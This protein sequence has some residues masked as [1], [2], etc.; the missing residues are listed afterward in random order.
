MIYQFFWSLQH[1]KSNVLRVVLLL[2]HVLVENNFG[3]EEPM[4][5]FL[6]DL[7]GLALGLLKL[8]LD[9]EVVRVQGLQDCTLSVLEGLAPV[10]ELFLNFLLDPLLLVSEVRVLLVEERGVLELVLFVLEALVHGDQNLGF[11]TD[12]VDDLLLL[13]ELVVLVGAEQGAVR[14]NSELARHANQVQLLVVL[15]AQALL[16][17]LLL[18]LALLELLRLFVVELFKLLLPFL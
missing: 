7:A 15:L 6:A 16:R 10:L 14:T 3:L 9:G 2:V 8:L 12:F 18:L 5:G 17:L 4:V 13:F 11:E 1:L